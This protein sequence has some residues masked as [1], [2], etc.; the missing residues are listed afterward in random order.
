MLTFDQIITRSRLSRVRF[1]NQQQTLHH[2]GAALGPFEVMI[3]V[4]ANT[5]QEL[6]YCRQWAKK[7]YAFEAARVDSVWLPLR[8]QSDEQITCINVALAEANESRQFWPASNNW[9]SSSLF[10][11]GGHLT[12]FSHVGFG[13]P[14]LV[15]CR[16]LDSFAFADDCEVLIM[17]VQGAEHNVLRGISNY[18]NIQLILLEF[19]SPGLYHSGSTFVD[20]EQLLAS[21]GFVFVEAFDIY[22]NS[23]SSAYAGNA[24]FVKQNL[25]EKI[26]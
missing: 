2:Y 9:E 24:V 22:Y 13:E 1:A 5:G 20:C 3:Y 23:I 25:L 18:S 17:D 19:T 11:P 10:Q 12:E 6:P 26:V 8:N 4:G 21:Q 16:R 7:I 15:E 14:S